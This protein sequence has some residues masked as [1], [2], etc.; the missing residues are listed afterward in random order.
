MDFGAEPKQFTDGEDLGGIP[1]GE[2]VIP[3][4]WV[5]I[6][7]SLTAWFFFGNAQETSG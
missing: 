6:E 4:V 5:L 2:G 7:S 3:A 1:V